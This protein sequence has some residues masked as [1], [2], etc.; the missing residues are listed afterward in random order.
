MTSLMVSATRARTSSRS[1][2]LV[3]LRTDSRILRSFSSSAPKRMNIIWLT[4][5]PHQRAPVQQAPGVE[6]GPRATIE[7]L[8]MTVLSRSKKAARTVQC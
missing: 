3:T 1:Q 8:A 6:L 7:D 4:H 5:G 2:P